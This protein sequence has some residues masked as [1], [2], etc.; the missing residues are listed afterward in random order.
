MQVC[1]QRQVGR[2]VGHEQN[3]LRIHVGLW[4]LLPPSGASSTA[5]WAKVSAN[6]LSGRAR[7]QARV[8]SHPGRKE[9]TISR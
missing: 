9:V 1:A 5:Y 4:A 2:T 8:P 3:G 7:I 6:P